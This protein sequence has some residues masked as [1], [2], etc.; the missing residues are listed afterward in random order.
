MPDERITGGRSIQEAITAFRESVN[1]PG[2]LRAANH[3]LLLDLDH[4]EQLL[5]EPIIQ[6]EAQALLDVLYKRRWMDEL[7]RWLSDHPVTWEDFCIYEASPEQRRVG[8]GDIGPASKRGF[9][10]CR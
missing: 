2:T 4:V 7:I 1:Q 9:R 10:D 5:S 6:E 3:S 8:P